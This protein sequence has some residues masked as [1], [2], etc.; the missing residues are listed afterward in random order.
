[1]QRM[2]VDAKQ[3][4]I[5]QTVARAGDFSA[6]LRNLV[7]G[8]RFCLDAGARLV[9]APAGALDGALPG[10]LRARASFLLQSR[11]ALRA[12]ADELSIPLLL[13]CYAGEPGTPCVAPQPFLLHRGQVRPLPNRRTVTVAGL[14]VKADTSRELR[15][16][17]AGTADVL[18]HLPSG[19]WSQEDTT[20]SFARRAAAA[21]GLPCLVLRSVAYSHGY[22]AGGGSVVAL[23]GGK[24]FCLPPFEQAFLLRLPRTVSR[25]LRPLDTSGLLLRAICFALREAVSQGGFRGVALNAESPRAE[26]LSALTRLALG[27]RSVFVLRPEA[28]ANH[29]RGVPARQLPRISLPQNCSSRVRAA[30]LHDFAQEHNLLLLSTASR[31]EYLCEEPQPGLLAPLADLYESELAALCAAL[32]AAASKQRPCDARTPCPSPRE[33]A[34]RLLID[35]NRCPADIAAS[36]DLDETLLRSL[37]R[38]IDRAAALRPSHSSPQ[39][40]HLRRDHRI[41]PSHHRLM[42]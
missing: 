27:A 40:L 34:L 9:V 12:L 16:M 5:V 13:P 4:A 38:R 42:E 10:S 11:A 22:L 2:P 20:L 3:L 8:V 26:L 39:I 23:P 18:L 25:S 14:R 37:M 30:V 29:R 28:T 24:T 35:A 32:I 15:P 33:L 31:E 1:M 19:P 36:T 21:S 41:P 7:Q 17:S 6:N